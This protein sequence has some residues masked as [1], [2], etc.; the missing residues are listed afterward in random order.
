MFIDVQFKLTIHRRRRQSGLAPVL[1]HGSSS[2][3][4]NTAYC[5]PLHATIVYPFRFRSTQWTID[6]VLICQTEQ[7]YVLNVRPSGVTADK[8]SDVETLTIRKLTYEIRRQIV[9]RLVT[10]AV[11]MNGVDVSTSDNGNYIAYSD[12]FQPRMQQNRVDYADT[13]PSVE[14]DRH[15]DRQAGRRIGEL[16]DANGITFSVKRHYTALRQTIRASS[17]SRWN[18]NGRTA[19][20]RLQAASSVQRLKQEIAG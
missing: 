5:I 11:R 20:A 14:W 17:T 13:R 18:I 10:T 4:E 3:D 12:S 9:E 15:T 1:E 6:V 2:F 7:C 19:A 16:A 8:W